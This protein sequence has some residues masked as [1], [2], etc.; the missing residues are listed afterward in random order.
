MDI[1]HRGTTLVKI[2]LH[3]PKCSF[4]K[5]YKL[6][7]HIGT[8]CFFKKVLLITTPHYCLV[9]P[10]TQ[11]LY[12]MQHTH[13]ILWATPQLLTT[14]W[15]VLPTVPLY[16]THPSP[17]PWAIPQLLS[18]L[19]ERCYLQYLSTEHTHLPF[20]GQSQLVSLLPERCYLFTKHTP[21]PWFS[22]SNFTNIP[23]CCT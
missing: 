5:C 23:Q 15:E 16:W 2:F 17:I 9:P 22:N 14:A 10:K 3:F 12:W 20:H 11:P 13:I 19:P 1:E 7:E 18:L 4:K 21:L 8:T 6:S